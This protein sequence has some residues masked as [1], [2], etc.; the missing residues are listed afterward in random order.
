MKIPLQEIW[1]F[2]ELIDADEK[3]FE[4]TLEAGNYTLSEI[5]SDTLKKLQDD[6]EFDTEILPSLFTY[7]FLLLL[8][9]PKQGLGILG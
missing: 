7:F 8:L 3:G 6:Q 5:K 9:A 4:F 2:I 1:N